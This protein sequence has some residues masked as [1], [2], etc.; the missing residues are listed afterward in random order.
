MELATPWAVWH[1]GAGVLSEDDAL[2]AIDAFVAYDAAE[3]VDGGDI[4]LTSDGVPVNMHDTTTARTC[5]TTQTVASITAA[6]FSGLTLS[7]RTPAVPMSENP[8]TMS[9]WWDK[10]RNLGL[11][12]APEPKVTA[13]AQTA[14]DMIVAKGMQRQCVF[15][16][17]T[18]ADITAA[19]NAGMTTIYI[20]DTSP[21]TLASIL[22]VGPDLVTFNFNRSNVTIPD[23]LLQGLWNAGIGVGTWTI[24][25][26]QDLADTVARLA[27]LGIPLNHFYTNDAA[28]V[29]NINVPATRTTDPFGA[30]LFLP[31][32]VVGQPFQSG[33]NQTKFTRGGYVGSAGSY[34]L[35][36]ADP[37]LPQSMLQGWM[38]PATSASS[39]IT[40]SITYDAVGSSTARWPGVW[41]NCPTDK[42]VY[43]GATSATN[44]GQGYLAFLRVTG[45][46]EL[47]REA[48]SD[49]T[50]SPVSLGTQATAA[51]TSG[52]TA[53]IKIEPN[54]AGGQIRVY[55]HR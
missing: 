29:K 3:V 15:T 7:A 40:L 45:S 20:I 53:T 6:T 32:M 36:L 27:A 44:R 31:G 9:Q 52:Q 46:L 54:L 33:D 13:A 38:T 2:R 8:P 10:V 25:T 43:N 48:P 41:F 47:F 34:R 22:A 19:K 5:T 28:W 11:L 21:G 1:R 18:L 16:S 30:G 50:G 35:S 37:D 51:I 39:S 14:V 4:R 49:G 12:C 42:M 26:R 17:T 55:S 24:D 23:A